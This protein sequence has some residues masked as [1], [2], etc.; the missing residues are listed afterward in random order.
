MSSISEADFMRTHRHSRPQPVRQPTQ[1]NLAVIAE[2]RFVDSLTPRGRTIERAFPVSDFQRAVESV[3]LDEVF[4]ILSKHGIDLLTIEAIL[5]QAK[6]GSESNEE[7]M[8]DL[9]VALW[10]SAIEHSMADY[11]PA[12]PRFY[13]FREERAVQ[14][15]E[16]AAER[17]CQDRDIRAFDVFLSLMKKFR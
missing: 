14:L 15:A 16:M 2:R 10:T 11:L 3:D 4:S 8:D 5:S 17:L 13:Q 7:R 12:L 9:C 1:S 6:T